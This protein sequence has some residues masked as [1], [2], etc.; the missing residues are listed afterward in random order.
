LKLGLFRN[1]GL[2]RRRHGRRLCRIP[3]PSSPNWPASLTDV[4][5][6][7]DRFGAPKETLQ[8]RQDLKR[9]DKWPLL[10]LFLALIGL[11]WILRRN[12]GLNRLISD[13]IKPQQSSIG[14]RPSYQ[15]SVEICAICG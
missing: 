9:Y 7:I 4:N 8:E 5:G 11:E 14:V 1:V 6:L 15:S 3:R 10:V 12:A 2:G 13:P